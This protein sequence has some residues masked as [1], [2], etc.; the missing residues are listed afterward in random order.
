[1]QTA[2]E[3]VGGTG[4]KFAAYKFFSGASTSMVRTPFG[5]TGLNG[6]AGLGGFVASSSGGVT[7]GAGGLAVHP[8]APGSVTAF[9]GSIGGGVLGGFS[10]GVTATN[11]SNP[12]QLGKF[13][14]FGIADYLLYAARQVCK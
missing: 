13:A 1:L 10:R 3:D 5:F 8:S 6:G 4:A 9:G 12:F 7:G 2:I 14:A 11:Y